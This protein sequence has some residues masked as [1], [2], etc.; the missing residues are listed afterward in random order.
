MKV[1]TAKEMRQ[2][3]QQTIEEIGIPGA[4]LMEH[5]GTAVVRTIRQHF[6]ECPAYRGYRRQRKQRWRMDWSLP[7]N[8]C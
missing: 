5:A 7:D 2:I 1:V 3:D 8:S 6:P 4:V